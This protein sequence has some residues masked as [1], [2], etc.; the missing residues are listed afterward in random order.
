MESEPGQTRVFRVIAL[1]NFTRPD[2]A[3]RPELRYF[4]EKIVV[5]IKEKREP[6]REIVDL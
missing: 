6:F 3:R 5:R 1:S 4:L 2:S